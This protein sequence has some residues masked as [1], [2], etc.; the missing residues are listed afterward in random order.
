MASDFAVQSLPFFVYD[1]VEGFLEELA[2]LPRAS[3]SPKLLL[4][5]CNGGR[6]AEPEDNWLYAF[7]SK[8]EAYIV[9][10]LLTLYRS[11]VGAFIQNEWETLSVK[12]KQNMRMGHIGFGMNIDMLVPD[13]TE[14]AI[15]FLG[16]QNERHLKVI[17]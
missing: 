3:K 9:E 1:I 12:I 7:D 2:Q 15:L 6:Y 4:T 17:A 16:Y 14:E 11:N 8:A 13:D 10:S 5:S